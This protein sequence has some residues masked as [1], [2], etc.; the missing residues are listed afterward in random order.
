V[1]GVADSAMG[2]GRSTSIDS[3]PSF[4]LLATEDDEGAWPSD[5]E[6]W[7]EDVAFLLLELGC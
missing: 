4:L 5:E 2:C 6:V 1:V 7:P 3:T